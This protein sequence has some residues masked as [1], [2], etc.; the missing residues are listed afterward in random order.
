MSKTGIQSLA[1]GRKD[2]LRIAPAD[3]HIREGWNCRDVNFNPDDEDDLALAK[4]IAE[5]GVKQPLT[6][7][8]DEQKAY[9]TDGH[10]RLLATIYAIEHLSAD[11]KSVPVQTEDRYANE[12]ERV[13]SQI[14]RNNGKPLSAIE[15]SRVYKRL[16]DLG[17]TEKE[18][19]SKVGR[20][21]QWVKN[22]LQLNAAPAEVANMVR[23]NKVSATMAL[24]ALKD[25]GGDVTV[26]A[27]RL[28]DAIETAKAAG[29]KR[30]TP[31][32]MV[33]KVSAKDRHTAE[34]FSKG[35]EAVI[36]WHRA[37][38]AS[39]KDSFGETAEYIT[40]LQ[41]ADDIAHEVTEELEI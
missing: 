4:S 5:V 23:E 31:K 2:V 19:A 1:V 25:S 40:H 32:Y 34:G 22:L 20:S 10:R 9:L 6:A 37:R 33:I 13:L 11:I 36:D 26:A 39:I 29:K 41:C 18:I 35:V 3:L 21:I 15:F 17:W 12:A 28:M 7:V 16:I 8:W 14:V 38:A 24:T 30:A 27:D